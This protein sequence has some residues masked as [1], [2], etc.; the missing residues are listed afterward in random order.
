MA[1]KATV[2]I[3]A[4]L[5]ASI[6]LAAGALKVRKIP[7]ADGGQCSM[8]GGKGGDGGDGGGGETCGGKPGR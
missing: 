7:P 4:A 3:A 8:P 6:I 1:K 5:L 2:E